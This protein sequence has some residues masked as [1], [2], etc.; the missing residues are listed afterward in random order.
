MS[1]CI[2]MT[3]TDISN[4]SNADLDNLLALVLAE[5]ARRSTMALATETSTE[6]STV[7]WRTVEV[8]AYAHFTSEALTEA[9]YNGMTSGLCRTAEEARTR[10][11]A[12]RAGRQP[13]TQAPDCQANTA[14]MDTAWAKL[15]RGAIRDGGAC[16][17]AIESALKAG[18]HT[19]EWAIASRYLVAGWV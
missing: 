18:I 2:N 9:T 10:I 3:N 5:S 15:Q 8:P 1:Y 19:V 4:L 17:K 12:L 6:A 11:E 13:R 7:G 16:R 14:E